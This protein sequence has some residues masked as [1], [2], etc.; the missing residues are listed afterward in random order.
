[1]SPSN[2]CCTS[3]CGSSTLLVR[4][5]LPMALRSLGFGHSQLLRG[6]DLRPVTGVVHHSVTI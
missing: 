4:L 3:G 1:M 5:F 2:V 6:P